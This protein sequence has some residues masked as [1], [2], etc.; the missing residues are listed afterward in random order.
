M[1]KDKELLAADFFNELLVPLACAERAAEKSF[2]PLRAE[3]EA[4]SYYVEPARRVMTAADF[5]L[6][7]A[8]SIAD[9]VKELAALWASEGHEELAALAPRLFELA[10][11]MGEQEKQA[12]DVSPF[13]YVMF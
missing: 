3:D 1:T 13:M 5:E 10:Q 11:E 2:F 9:F 8:E 12:E 6:R 7:A 4:E